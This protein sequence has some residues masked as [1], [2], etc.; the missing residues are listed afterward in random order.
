[1]RIFAVSF[2]GKILK[3][4]TFLCPEA[5]GQAGESQWPGSRHSPGGMQSL[6]ADT[7]LE[8]GASYELHFAAL[9]CT[10]LQLSPEP[11]LETRDCPGHQMSVSGHK[12]AEAR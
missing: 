8:E 2:F 7:E 11:G 3:I 4:S 5:P 10:R 1:M 12:W 6:V 9:Y